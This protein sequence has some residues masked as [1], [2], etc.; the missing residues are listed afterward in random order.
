MGRRRVLAASL[1]S[2]LLLGL[3]LPAVSSAAPVADPVL[4]PIVDVSAPAR[5]VFSPDVA[6]DGHGRAVAVWVARSGGVLEVNSARR[7]REGSW[8]EPVTL[9]PAGQNAAEAVVGVDR[10]GNALAVWSAN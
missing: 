6:V 3:P 8:T 7:T 10:A 5:E 1:S 4:G 2:A 9:S